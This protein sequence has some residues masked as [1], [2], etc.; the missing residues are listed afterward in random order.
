MGVIKYFG[1]YIFIIIG[2]CSI[3]SETV[4]FSYSLVFLSFG[5]IPLLELVLPPNKTQ[6]TKE[7]ALAYDLIIYSL[8]PLFLFLMILFLTTIGGETNRL[9]L[10]GKISAMG[11]LIG[12]FGINMAHELGHRKSKLDRFLAQLLLCSSQYTHF[13]IEHNR[14]HHKRVA[15]PD[16]PATARKGENLF[17]FW[18]RSIKDAYTSAWHLENT[19]TQKKGLPKFSWQND[20]VKYT[21]FQLLILAIIGLSFGTPVLLYYILATLI[22]IL[23]LE[24]INYLEHYGLLRK[25]ISEAAYERVQDKHSWNSDHILGRYLLFEL[26]RHSHH[27]ANS[28]VKYPDLLSREGSPQLPTGYPGMI[29]LSLVP[30]LFFKVMDKKLKKK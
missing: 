14:G 2:Y 5:L 30:P 20:M 3:A 28:L 10:Y 9:I 15:T 19:S 23:L 25:K 12:I 13:Y 27:H 21:V 22:G 1:T 7:S 18:I 16:D 8:V 17:L 11:I 29:L 26:T 4:L 24:S 6:T